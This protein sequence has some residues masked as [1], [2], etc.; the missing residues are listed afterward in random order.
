VPIRYKK[1]AYGLFKEAGRQL[2]VTGGIGTAILPVRFLTPPE[3]VVLN[4]IPI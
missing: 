3:I 1:Y 4:L 2:Y